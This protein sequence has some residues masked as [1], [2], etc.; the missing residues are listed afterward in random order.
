M[1]LIR[2]TLLSFISTVIRVIAGLVANKVIAV[3]AGPG[4]MAL[5]GN[6]SNF[7]SFATNVGSGGIASGVVK[8]V[9]EYRQDDSSRNAITATAFKIT[10]TFSVGIG[11]ALIAFHPAIGLYLFRTEGYG[12]I[13]LITGLTLLPIGL[14]TFFVSLLNGNKNLEEVIR[15]TVIGSIISL[16]ITIMLTIKWGLYG[17]LLSQ[18]IAQSLIFLVTLAIL[19]RAPWFQPGSWIKH[20]VERTEFVKLAKF[21]LMALISALSVPIAFLFIRNYIIDNISLDAAGQWQGVWK[22]SDTYLML[23]TS[24]LSIYYLPRLSEIKHHNELRHEILQCFRFLLPIT[25]ISASVIYLLRESI[26]HLLFTRQFDRMLELFAFQL[27]GDVFK[28]ASWILG[29]LTVARAMT[30]VFIVCEIG[31]ILT[32]VLL[33]ILFMKQWGLIGV[34]YAYALNYLLYLVTMLWVFR[35]I[36]R[37]VE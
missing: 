28:I 30:R 17:A 16:V 10:L 21:S 8:Y 29:Y 5:M 1:T 32:F 25:I 34:T 23:V 37:H 18:S 31:F 3:Y 12:G 13:I 7:L 2:T 22:I 36:F 33:S 35:K 4:G 24:S 27:I 11:V 15:I 9:A 26:V 6:M 20:I 14:N 19:W